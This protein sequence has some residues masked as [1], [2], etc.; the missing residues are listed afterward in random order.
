MYFD[1]YDYEILFSIN[2]FSKVSDDTNEIIFI[3]STKLV[4]NVIFN[5]VRM[6]RCTRSVRELPRRRYTVWRGREKLGV[7]KHLSIIVHKCRLLIVCTYSFFS[8]LT[9]FQCWNY[10][11]AI[12][13]AII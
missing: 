11:R 13:C 12:F 9:L 7:V 3:H 8:E 2:I 4:V 10:N 5:T 1:K 6:P